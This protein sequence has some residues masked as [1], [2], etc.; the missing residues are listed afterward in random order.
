MS[1][2]PIT[3]RPKVDASS[4][5]ADKRFGK[6]K[7]ESEKA[8]RKAEIAED[9]T[10]LSIEEAMGRFRRRVEEKRPTVEADRRVESDWGEANDALSGLEF[11][12]DDVERFSIRLKDSLEAEDPP[13]RSMRPSMVWWHY[14]TPSYATVGLFLSALVARCDGPC[15]IIL[16]DL[17]QPISFVAYMN[18]KDLM[19]TGNAG[20]RFAQCMRSGTVILNGD[21]G[22]SAASHME[23]G[24]LTINGNAFDFLAKRMEGGKATLKGNATNSLGYEM[25]GG[26]VIIDGDVGVETGYHMSGGRITIGGDAD[27]KLGHGSTGGEIFLNGR[28]VNRRSYIGEALGPEYASR[29]KVGASIW[30]RG[31]PIRLVHPSKDIYRPD[32]SYK[33]DLK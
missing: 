26:E 29:H 28:F 4:T 16:P 5:A 2:S 32:W 7:K 11:T 15:S 3:R 22:A 24:E 6:Y 10:L 20:D 23:G 19:V 12:A 14:Q 13:R 33:I 30:Y 9:K 21:A 27:A 8:T 25:Q 31:W 1:A 18:E 17:R